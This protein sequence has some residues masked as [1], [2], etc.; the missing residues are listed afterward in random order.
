MVTNKIYVQIYLPVSARKRLE[1]VVRNDIRLLDS[2]IRD[3]RVEFPNAFHTDETLPT[4]QF[5]SPPLID[6]TTP[7]TKWPNRGRGKCVS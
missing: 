4:R 1:E 7:N 3:L 6:E 2:V 5:V